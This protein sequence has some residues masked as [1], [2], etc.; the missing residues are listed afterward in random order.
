[1]QVSK[2]KFSMMDQLLLDEWFYTQDG[3]LI[4]EVDPDVIVT[5]RTALKFLEK[6]I[7]LVLG[8]N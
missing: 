1:M 4:L 7:I 6:K 8:K 2:L 3:N 5:N